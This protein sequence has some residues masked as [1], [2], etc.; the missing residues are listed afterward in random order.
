MGAHNR[1]W[2][3]ANVHRQA[4]GTAERQSLLQHGL[5]SVNVSNELPMETDLKV[6]SEARVL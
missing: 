4:R 2:Y 5:I 1:A 6:G 3:K